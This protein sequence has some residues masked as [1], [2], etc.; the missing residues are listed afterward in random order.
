M[1]VRIERREGWYRALE[2]GTG[3]G[4]RK[5]KTVLQVRWHVVDRNGVCIPGRCGEANQSSCGWV[6]LRDARAAV[7]T[8]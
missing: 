2:H 3:H 1:S 5:A 7:G 8:P 6:R 4:H